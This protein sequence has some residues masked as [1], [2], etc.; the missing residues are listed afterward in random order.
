MAEWFTWVSDPSAWVTLLTLTFLEIVLGVDNI[1]VI[2]IL[3]GKLP[4]SQQK[5]ARFVGLFLAMFMRIALLLTISIIV[6]MTKPMF[7]IGNWGISGRDLVLL[8][9]G[10]FLIYK[11]VKEIREKFAVAHHTQEHAVKAT[12]QSVIIQIIILDIVFSLDSVITAVGIAQHI[13]IMVIAIVVAVL[14]MMFLSGPISDLVDRYP[15][16]KIM[17]LMFLILIGILL[18]TEGFN[19]HIIQKSAIYIAMGFALITE[20]INIQLR[21]AQRHHGEMQAQEKATD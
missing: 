7:F 11:S 9:G 8:L 4:K 21:K 10:A 1:I 3:T 15:S 16:L 19:L 20:V 14:V 6:A 5:N 13:P 18:V 12:F 2:S 17:A